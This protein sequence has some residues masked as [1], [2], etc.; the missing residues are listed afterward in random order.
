MI[1]K[2]RLFSKWADHQGITDFQLVHAVKEIEQGLTGISLGA[3]LYK[4]RIAAFGKGKS[5]G[6]RTI[7]A[8]SEADRT[9]FLY[10]FSKGQ[11]ENIEEKELF[12]LKDF[13]K[14]YLKY[15]HAELLHAL[16]Q[17]ELIEVKK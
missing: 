6:V 17:K 7:L 3:G 16:D 9:I 14:R 13:S 10:G 8:Y 11:R 5:G 2:N 12:L 4:K 15:T 1:L